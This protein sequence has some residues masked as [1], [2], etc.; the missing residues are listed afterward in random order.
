MGLRF[1]DQ[2]YGFCFFVTTSFHEHR[3]LGDVTG[4]YEALADSLRYYLD[5]YK[6]LLPAYVFMPT[7]IH[8]L[9]VVDGD[10]LGPFMRDFRKYVAQKSIQDCSFVA[11]PVWQSRFDR[12]VVENES[13]FRQKLQYIHQNPAKAGIVKTSEAWNW[14]SARAYV[15]EA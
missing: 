7:H 15:E 11:P 9:L 2:E 5:K 8:L 1:R 12:V 3:R 4:V 6:A 14:S 10:R 13:V